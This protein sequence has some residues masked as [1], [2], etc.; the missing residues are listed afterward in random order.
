M[1]KFIKIPPQKENKKI[2]SGT[3]PYLLLA[4]FNKHLKIKPVGSKPEPQVL[5]QHQTIV[6]LN[7][8]YLFL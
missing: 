1:K 5:F 6:L 3:Y 7:K 8:I 4:K 2:N